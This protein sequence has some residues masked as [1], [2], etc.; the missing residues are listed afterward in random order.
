M[1]DEVVGGSS[2]PLLA[3]LVFRLRTD[4]GERSWQDVRCATK[5]PPGFPGTYSERAEVGNETAKY[6]AWFNVK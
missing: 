5:R 6:V 4:Q 2:K 1:S 3:A